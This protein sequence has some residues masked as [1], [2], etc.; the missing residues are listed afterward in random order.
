MAVLDTT[1]APGHGHGLFDRLLRAAQSALGRLA[2]WND[3]RLTRKA[4]SRLSDRELDDIGLTRAD[5]EFLR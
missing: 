5:V 1:R 4:L 2:Q 3:V